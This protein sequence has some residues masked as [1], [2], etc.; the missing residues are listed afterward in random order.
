MRVPI[1]VEPFPEESL[2]GYL[3]RVGEANGIRFDRLRFELLGRKLKPSYA[4][5]GAFAER[6]RILPDEA[7]RLGG[8]WKSGEG[9]KLYSM[10]G[11]LMLPECMLAPS[12]GRVPRCEMC[13][14]EYGYQKSIWA[15]TL[16]TTCHVH[17]VRLY[18]ACESC[19]RPV[20]ND[21]WVKLTPC[22]CKSKGPIV[23]EASD[24]EIAL[25][26]LVEDGQLKEVPA[27]LATSLE[28]LALE[29]VHR[30]LHTL[31]FLSDVF[32]RQARAL[33]SD[34]RVSS[35]PSRAYIAQQLLFVL[36][37]W[38]AGF[39]EVFAKMSI[40]DGQQTTVAAMRLWRLFRY[41][42]SDELWACSP[43]VR[44]AFEAAF[45]ANF[46]KTLRRSSRLQI[47]ESLDLGQS[48]GVG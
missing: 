1:R 41:Y 30:R 37:D 38:P 20:G 14:R 48:K 10:A 5:L 42:I 18:N 9:G 22:G 28:Y 26:R 3:T 36:S 12:M 29:P 33:I 27:P 45:N 24:K 39:N 46:C 11:R 7:L 17:G 6:C 4:L 21:P 47:Q 23:A 35:C 31:H 8:F 19:G 2:H 40:R 25:A 32:G 16:L 15:C 43:F 44:S 13:V 34:R